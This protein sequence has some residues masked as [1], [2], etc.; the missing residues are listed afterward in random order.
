MPEVKKMLKNVYRSLPFKKTFFTALRKC[1]IP[2][3]A[4]YRHL[5]FNGIILIAAGQGDTQTFKMVH[6]GHQLEN[7]IFWKGLFNGW[8]KHS[9]RIWATLAAQADV[10]F[11]IGANTG[12]YSLVAKAKNNRA[13]VHAFEPFGAICT[14][15][16]R[17]ASLNKYDIRCN[18][19][20]VSD[21]TG[22]AV[23]YTAD[24]DFAYSVTVN[25]NLWVTE[26]EPIKLDIK[27]ITL[28]DYIEQQHITKLDLV[29]IDVETHEPEVMAGF[30]KYFLHL[31]PVVLIEIL[32][33][34]VA[35]KLAPYFPAQEFDFY[36]IDERSG[37]KKVA[38]LSKS[39]FYN[40]LI[41]PK[42]KAHLYNEESFIHSR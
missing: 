33:E 37:I 9:M 34:N 2:P 24:K 38:A 4:I 14:K 17:N 3:E 11:D 5:H 41:V 29:K 36:N 22:D 21:Y 6:Y 32:N 35:E 26:G 19:L 23:I 18:C 12:V 1:W 15:L 27:T 42:E 7:D 20:A 31:K 28:N 13:A 8:E 10:I 25:Q 30:N 40:F 39:D 16:S